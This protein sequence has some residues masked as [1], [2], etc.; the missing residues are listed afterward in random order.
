MVVLTMSVEAM[1]VRV[2]W[3]EGST[4]ARVLRMV[5]VLREKGTLLLLR[6]RLRGWARV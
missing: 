5:R 2:K 6:L 4:V 3:L 1:V